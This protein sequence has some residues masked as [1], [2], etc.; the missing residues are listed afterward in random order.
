MSLN[1]LL[2]PLDVLLILMKGKISLIGNEYRHNIK[3]SLMKLKELQN[4]DEVLFWGRIDGTFYFPNQ[5][6][7][8][9]LLYSIG[10]E[11]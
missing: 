4:L 5:R 3:L 8:E 7:N 2:Q 11:I 10:F 1:M 9:G 6:R